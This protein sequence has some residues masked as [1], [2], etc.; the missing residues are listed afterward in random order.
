M[1]R[2]ERA[3]VA[4]GRLKLGGSFFFLSLFFNEWE[5]LEHALVM[6]GICQ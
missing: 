1:E 3:V 4:E 6:M 2:V 5:T